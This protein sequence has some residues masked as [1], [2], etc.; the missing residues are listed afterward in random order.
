MIAPTVD[1]FFHKAAW[2]FPGLWRCTILSL[3]FLNS[4]LVLAML[5]VGFLLIV[6]GGRVSLCS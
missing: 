3:V 6:W 1:L 4:S 5:V 2:Q